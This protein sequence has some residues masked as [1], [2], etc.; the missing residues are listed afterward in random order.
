M[1]LSLKSFFHPCQHST[2]EIR[3]PSNNLVGLLEKLFQVCSS[4]KRQQEFTELK[5]ALCNLSCNSGLSRD[6]FS[7]LLSS[8]SQF[9]SELITVCSRSDE[10]FSNVFKQSLEVLMLFV[11]HPEIRALIYRSRLLHDFSGKLQKST[12]NISLALDFKANP[13]LLHEPAKLRYLDEVVKFWLAV[14]AF[15][16]SHTKIIVA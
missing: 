1:L 10:Q 8:K 11:G 13:N 2:Q 3:L 14:S 9:V 5:K 16:D 12:P 6:V 7:C 15:K 4:K